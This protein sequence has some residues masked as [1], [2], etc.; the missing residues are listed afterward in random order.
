MA[1]APMTSEGLPFIVSTSTKKPD[2]EMRKFI[3]SHVMIGKNLGKI[4]RPRRSKAGESSSSEESHDSRLRSSREK[5]GYDDDD[6]ELITLTPVV[7]PRRVGGDFSFIRFAD[8][9]E[10]SSIAVI[11]EFSSIAKKALFPL[12]S[13]IA[14]AAREKAGWMEALTVDAAYLHALAFSTRAYFDLMPNGC[15]PSTS[16]G[17]PAS[18]SYRHMLKTL[19]LLRE[20]LD[21]PPPT[22]HDA[23]GAAVEKA[24]FS[25]AAVVLC[26]AFHAHMTGERETARHHLLGLRK[27][28]DLKGGLAGLGNVKLVIE[29]LRCDMAMA[30]HNGTQPLFFAD[31]IREP[32]WAYP[33]FSL[34]DI[35]CDPGDEDEPVLATTT[36]NA[37]LARAWRA[38]KQFCTLVNRAAAAGTKL[39][40]QTLLAAMAAVTYRLLH[41]RRARGAPPEAEEAVRVG[42][43]AFCSGVFLQWASVRL[44]YTHFPRV[45][46]ATVVDLALSVPAPTPI[47][48]LGTDHHPYGSSPDTASSLPRLLVWLLT[49]GA[50]SLFGAADTEGWLKPLLRVNLERCGVR[51]WPAMRAVLDSF[52]WIGIV[53]D[54]PGKALFDSVMSPSLYLQAV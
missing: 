26:L 20:R 30:L 17:H 9:I 51:S 4:L 46:R 8:T 19:R 53:H 39:P 3:R 11:L 1:P 29:L 21:A 14:F 43:L 44:P 41:M 32:Y 28:V 22:E 42:L 2:P 33:D 36:W 15:T 31:P 54:A 45:Y 49:I 7:V 6:D 40:E 34:Y 47:P 24:S 10:D 52:M 23:A 35:P 5:E 25:T 48:I 12:E 18:A 38:M 50:V 27:I 37:E 13:C 16:T